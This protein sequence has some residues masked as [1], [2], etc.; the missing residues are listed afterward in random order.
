MTPR[1]ARQERR[2]ADRK[3]RKAEIRRSKAGL[4]PEPNLPPDTAPAHVAPAPDHPAP[5][6]VTL[7]DWIESARRRN[8]PNGLPQSTTPQLEFVSQNAPANRAAI[9]RANAQLS[10]GPRTSHGKL[11]SSR[12]S[13]THG[14]A[15]SQPL[16]AGEDPAAFEA[17][18]AGLLHDHQPVNSTETLL[19]NQM[20][21][22]HW[23]QQRAVRLQNDCFNESGVDEKSL[24][25]FLR[26]GNTHSRAFYKALADLQRLQKER[27]QAERVQ[28]SPKR[29][30]QSPQHGFVSH[31]TAKLSRSDDFVLPIPLANPLGSRHAA[32]KTLNQKV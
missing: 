26:Y 17:L 15:S 13:T 19:V 1:Q 10:T 2:A 12:N 27:R 5:P 24:S 9:N 31:N 29:V 28:Q 3:T 22:S 20:A 21:Q 32:P 14:L 8:F 18:L 30:Q 25:L 4:L 6:T 23:L 11:V 7:T 16:I